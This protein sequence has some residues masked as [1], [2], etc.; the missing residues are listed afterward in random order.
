RGKIDLIVAIGIEPLKAAVKAT[1]EN[2]IPIILELGINPINLDFVENFQKPGGNVTGVSWQVDELTAKRLEFLKMVAPEVKHIT[3]FRQRNTKTMEVPLQY[4]KPV[5]ENLGVKYAVKEF[6]DLEDLKKL[7]SAT[8]AAD[9]DAIFY[10]SDPFLSRNVDLIIK[11]ALKE[12]LPTMFHDEMWAQKGALA[13]YGGNFN[14]AGRQGARQAAK[15]LFEGLSPSDV[16]VETVS[17]IDIVINLK[18]AKAIGLLISENV[19]SQATEIIH[20]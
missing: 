2:K 19:L 10:G 4:L 17:K 5:A 11:Q 14:A 18:T 12:K 1:A 3:I 8:Y 20:E 16:P 6:S 13:A 9:T 7:V 15:I